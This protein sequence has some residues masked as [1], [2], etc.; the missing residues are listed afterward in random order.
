[1]TI[2][3]RH[4]ISKKQSKKRVSARSLAAAKS[5][6][7]R[8]QART[9]AVARL[10]KLAE[11]RLRGDQEAK[12]IGSPSTKRLSTQAN[13]EKSARAVIARLPNSSFEELLRLWHSAIR[14]LS[15]LSSLSPHHP[16]MRVI[17]A[18]EREWQRRGGEEFDPTEYF[19]WPSTEANGG[20]HDL[21][22][23]GVLPEGMLQYL[24]YR[25][26]RTNGEATPTRQAILRRVFE[27]ILPP[28]FPADYMAS[29]GK[30]KSIQRLRKM[31]ESIAAF[32]RNAKRRHD[33]RMDDAI[34]HWES[35]LRFLFDTYYVGRFSF[36]WP[37]TSV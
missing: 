2:K 24:D 5:G 9:V 34:K 15:T 32:T 21:V 25:V 20:S 33:D 4:N 8:E 26:G 22:L 18:I 29:W 10:T 37:D 30:P 16:A 17:A 6:I 3:Q 7:S 1:M 19:D 13:L 36:G 31:A 11:I 12:T 23:T 14:I 35:D 27:G 28:V